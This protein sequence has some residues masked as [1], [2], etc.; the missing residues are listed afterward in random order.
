MVPY[1]FNLMLALVWAALT[2]EFS[3]H[4][5]AIGFVLGYL[6]LAFALR[7]DPVF[8][9][10]AR[11]VPRMLRFAGYFLWQ[12]LRSNL[13]VAY[14]VITPTHLMKPAIVAVPLEASTE[15]EIATLANLISLT[16][17]TLSLELSQDGRSLHVHVMYLDD[18]AAAIAE[19]KDLERRVLELLR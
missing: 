11:R 5:L 14:D 8:A 4:N 1:V 10:Y 19:I 17:G 9:A 3:A 15:G 12:L 7:A 13:R 18:E 2:G 6:L 16:P